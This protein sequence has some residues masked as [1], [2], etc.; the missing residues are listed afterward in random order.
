MLYTERE[1][2]IVSRTL[3][4]EDN[5][6]DGMI[7]VCHVIRN[8]YKI[9]L[10]HDGKYWW[11]NDLIDVCLKPYQFTCWLNNKE[12]SKNF[13]RIMRMSVGSERLFAI[14]QSIA[15]NV[16]CGITSDP[17]NGATHY[18]SAYIDAESVD[19]V[20]STNVS[21]GRFGNN[22]FYK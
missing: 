13:Q 10:E 6:S 18:H 19:W 21:L 20:K 17:T 15:I 5:D 2:D 12:G 9:T 8:R 16:L 7:A 3:I 11:G 14:A 4:G 22:I 1:L